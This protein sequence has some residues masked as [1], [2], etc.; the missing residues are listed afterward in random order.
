MAATSVA[1]APIVQNA[2]IAAVSTSP[3]SVICIMP[4]SRL[5]RIGVPS[6]RISISGSVKAKGI[7]KNIATAI[8]VRRVIDQSRPLSTL[9]LQRGQWAV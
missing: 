1:G 6:R 7:N 4:A 5:A 8:A 9:A 2:T 3:C